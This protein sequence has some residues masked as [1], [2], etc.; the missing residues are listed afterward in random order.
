[1]GED[2]YTHARGSAY[3]ISNID[4]VGIGWSLSTLVLNLVGLDHD[5]CCGGRGIMAVGWWG[6]ALSNVAR[7]RGLGGWGGGH[8]GFNEK[9]EK[10]VI[11]S[12]FGY[13]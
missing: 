9:K 1:M 10:I 4:S 2:T 11:F 5:R 3:L 6:G 12:P 8:V 13:K 7:T